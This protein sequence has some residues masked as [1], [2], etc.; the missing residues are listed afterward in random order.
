MLSCLYSQ[1]NCTLTYNANGSLGFY[2]VAIQ[3]EDFN[4]TSEVAMS[5]VPVQFLVQVQ[6]L[7][8][9]SN[10]DPP[11][12]EGDTPE[13]GSNITINIGSTYQWKITARSGGDD[14][15]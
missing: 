1:N 10:V 13:I 6:N 2:A 8:V 15:K 12:F 7:T 11:T 4:A 3:V 9:P 14:A 5:S